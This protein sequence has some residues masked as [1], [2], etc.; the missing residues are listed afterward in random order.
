MRSRSDSRDKMT[1]PA[2]QSISA[3]RIP[4]FSWPQQA[5]VA[6]IIA[7]ELAGLRGP[8]QTHTPMNVWDLR[9]RG[10]QHFD[11]ALKDGDTAALFVL[12]GAIHLQGQSVQASELAVLQRSGDM[13]TRPES[14]A[15][16]TPPRPA[17]S[18]AAS[19]AGDWTWSHPIRR[20]ASSCAPP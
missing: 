1:T 13:P 8:A 10:G 7:G 3:D 12:S 15:A 17:R 20:A 5:G 6:R 2:Y 19:A 9:L 4:L 14:P 18:P 11:I 16:A